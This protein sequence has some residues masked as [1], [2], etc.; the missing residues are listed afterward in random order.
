[1]SEFNVFSEYWKHYKET[2]TIWQRMGNG[3]RMSDVMQRMVCVC[4]SLLLFS[5]T[6]GL[7]PFLWLLYLDYYQHK[8]RWDHQHY[9]SDLDL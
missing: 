6:C 8:K 9:F 1:M 4:A 3:W 7:S 5:F 2:H